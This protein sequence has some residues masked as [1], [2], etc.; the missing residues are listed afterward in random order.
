MVKTGLKSISA[1]FWKKVV[2][3]RGCWIWAGAR[4][5]RGYGK[6]TVLKKEHRAHRMSWEL[7]NGEIPDGLC[8]CHTCDNPACVNPKHLFLGTHADN[9]TDMKNKGRRKGIGTGEAN[10][11]S[12]L[13]KENVAAIRSSSEN[14][15]AAGRRY[16]VSHSVIR[17]VRLGNSWKELVCHCNSLQTQDLND[18]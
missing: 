2:K 14:N 17:N 6:F 13:T 11:R 10:G 12:K 9:M 5:V 15:S 8:V 3:V 1:R 18:S 16:G 7:T 4:Y